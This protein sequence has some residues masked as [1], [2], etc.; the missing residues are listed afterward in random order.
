[1]HA[2]TERSARVRRQ[3]GRQ[4]VEAAHGR[5]QTA[6][7]AGE[8][9]D[10]ASWVAWLGLEWTLMAAVASVQSGSHLET[11]MGLFLC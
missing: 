10:T 4:S 5:R 1:M 6:S 7:E 9:S 3:A 2:R 11:S 8:A